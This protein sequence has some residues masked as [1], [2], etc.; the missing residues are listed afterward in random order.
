MTEPLVLIPGMMCDARLYD[1]QMAAF[2]NEICVTIAPVTQGERIEEIASNLL[3]Q[4]PKRFALAGLGFG[5]MVGME[6]LRRAPDRVS[7][8]ALISTNAQ[9]DTPQTAAA[10]EALIVGARAGRLDE[11][12]RTH[13]KPETLAPGAHRATVLSAVASMARTLGAE[14]FVRQ[15]RAMQRRRDQQSTLRKC[16]VPTLVMC[17][18]HDL[19]TPARH[20]SFMAELIHYAKLV[21]IEDAGHLPPL[22]QPEQTTAA[23]RAW[24]KQPMVLRS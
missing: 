12:M 20:H 16:R 2:S 4:L 15:S 17:G 24:M 8:I 19:L 3:D 11:V 7:R 6:I 18:A 21:V 13:L 5:A 10:R 22:E 14:V 1:A 9:A 23:L